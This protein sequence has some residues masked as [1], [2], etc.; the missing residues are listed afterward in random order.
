VGKTVLIGIEIRHR[1][2]AAARLWKGG[3]LRVKTR[4]RVR[5]RDRVRVRGRGS[6]V[7][8]WM[9]GVMATMRRENIGCPTHSC[10]V[11]D[12]G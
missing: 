3:G 9:S 2:F 11:E 8:G 10:A 5:V 12:W 7:L 6:G 4:V 1:D